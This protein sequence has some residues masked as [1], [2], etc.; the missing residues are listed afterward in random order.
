MSAG[1][2][3]ELRDLAVELRSGKTGIRPVDG[4]SL[5]VGRGEAVGIVGESGS[6]K[7]LTLRAI[8]GLL[9]PGARTGGTVRFEGGTGSVGGRDRG[10]GRG[11]RG[12]GGGHG[13]AGGRGG[14][15]SGGGRGGSGIA[16]VFQEPMTALNP[17]MRVGDLVAEPL[18]RAGMSRQAAAGRVVD[19]MRQVGIPDPAARAKAW[20][21]ELSGGLRQRVVI[22]AA[23]ATEPQLLLCDEPTTGL[24]VCVQDQILR[25]LRGLADE[26][27]MALLFVT[28]DL[29]VVGSL[30][31]RVAVMY[32]GRVVETGPADAVLSAPQ[33]PYTH[34]LLR[35]AP[36]LT[37]V[38]ERL[39]SIGGLPPDPR[40]F[41]PGCRFAPRCS[42]AQP[43]CTRID[44]ALIPLGADR[45]S[46]CIHPDL[47]AAETAAAAA[48]AGRATVEPAGADR[49]AVDRAAQS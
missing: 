37:E 43:D 23:L 7:S 26:R 40:A 31:D 39:W 27:G 25:L 11:G 38:S 41:P 13:S 3:L 12:R 6:G 5:R 2:L 46:A 35:S 45:A 19:L 32:A 34:G 42:F 15:G 36:S 8:L 1:E 33:H 28:H 22:A 44:G 16:M 49:A 18:R 9:P 20:P 10:G 4:V 21:H 47:L 14:N 30:C 48:P 29:A 24:D 17:T